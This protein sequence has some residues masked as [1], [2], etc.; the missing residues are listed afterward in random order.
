MLLVIRDGL[1]RAGAKVEGD[2]SWSVVLRAAE[3]HG[4]I[5]KQ[6]SD[7]VYGLSMLR[8]LAAHAG[9]FRREVQPDEAKEYLALADGVLY[10]IEMGGSVK[11][12]GELTATKIT[13]SG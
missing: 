3:D 2:A 5:S 4:V 7:A 8:N 10:A 1:E 12:T 6:T 13:R 9:R 11:P